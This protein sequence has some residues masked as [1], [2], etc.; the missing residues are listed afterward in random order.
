MYDVQDKAVM[1]TGA[2]VGLGYRYAEIL[3]RNGAK[4]AV[5][6]LPTSKGREA[7]ATLENEFGGSRV[8]FFGCDVTRADELKDTFEK[9][10]DT[11]GRLDVLINNAGML[12]DKHWERTIDLNVNALIRGSMLAFDHMG[13]QKDGKGGVIV[14][15]ASILGLLPAAMVPM[16]TAS[17]H[18][19]LGFSQSLAELHGKSGVRVVVM[20]PG[21]TATALVANIS[22]KMHDSVQDL[23]D[24]AEE[25]EKYPRQTTDNVAPAMLD[26]IRKGKNGQAWVSEGGQPPYAVEFIHYSKR[27]LPV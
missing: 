26:L 11:F 21:V 20:C 23:I 17:K 5:I 9:V 1:I 7:V 27:A 14:N 2:A 19:V 6:D 18:A 10:V 15:V 16:Y 13:K 12:N 25:M 8:V 24:I 3:L 4:V 22:E